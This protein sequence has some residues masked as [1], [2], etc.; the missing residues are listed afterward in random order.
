[1]ERRSITPRHNWQEK[2]ESLG[3]DF[4][5]IDGSIYWD[6]SAYYHFTASQVDELEQATEALQVMCDQAVASIIQ[7]SKYE[8]FGFSERDVSLIEKSYQQKSPSLYGRFDL[9]YDGVHPPK[10][11]EYNADTPTALFEAS[12]IQWEWLESLKLGVDQF[13]SIHEKL[14]EAWRN[15]IPSGAWLHLSG[16][17]DNAE[18]YGTI[19]YLADTALQV[20]K[21]VKVIGLH[22]V[23]LKD[24]F[25]KKRF[26]DEDSINIKYLFKLY[27]WEW[28]IK[29]EFADYLLNSEMMIL[30]PAWRM[31]L[32]NKNILAVLWEM[33]PDSPHLLPAYHSSSE[34]SS[35]FVAK[36]KW[37]REGEYVTLYQPRSSVVL[38]EGAE[39]SDFIY[40]EWFNVPSY[41]GNFPTIGS[42]VIQGKSAGIGIRED[43]SPIVKQSSRFIP[44]CFS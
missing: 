24:G 39:E 10:M 28:M 7:E 31:I 44:H 27:P 23:G 22:D 35:P 15:L 14:L 13:N 38:P 30:E 18:D 16:F 19:A 29:D 21:K 37:G 6:E 36:P 1:M 3:F 40:Q 17:L 8:G 11:L 34:F 41:D 42:W 12:V 33:F 43:L 26:C 20:T 9:A 4:H 25:F 5:T 32:Q 2:V